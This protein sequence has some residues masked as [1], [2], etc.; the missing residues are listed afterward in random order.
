MEIPLLLTAANGRNFLT[1]EAYDTPQWFAAVDWLTD[2]RFERTS[3][4]A[5]VQ[6]VL[7]L[8]EG[9][10]PSFVREE[11]TILA[12][13]D[14]WSGNYLLAECENGDKVLATLAN[15]VAAEGRRPAA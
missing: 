15:H 10:M 8:D 2:Q 9:I 11:I 1:F 13:W 7:G 3:Q 5:G 6:S 4:A 12:G 14:N